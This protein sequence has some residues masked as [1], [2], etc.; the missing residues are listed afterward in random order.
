MGPGCYPEAGP[1]DAITVL[2]V[3]KRHYFFA[4]CVSA[5]EDVCCTFS[6]WLG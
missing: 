3:V 1:C 5:S 6:E 4:F 2:G